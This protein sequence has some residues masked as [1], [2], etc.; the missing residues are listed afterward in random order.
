MITEMHSRSVAILQAE[1]VA[2]LTTLAQKHG[3]IVRQAGGTF[4]VTKATLKFEFAIAGE[5]AERTQ[6]TKDAPQI[7]CTPADYG[8]TA[9]INKETV[10][11]V[12]FEL[13][14]RAFPV[15]IKKADGKVVLMKED[16]LGKFFDTAFEKMWAKQKSSAF[17]VAAPTP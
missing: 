17:L 1:A 12:G 6:F 14:R 5:D 9:T 15:K 16:I 2:V 7:G 8:K 4:D 13:R 3:L 11:L 10:T